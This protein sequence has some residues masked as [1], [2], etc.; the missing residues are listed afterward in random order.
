MRQTI[1]RLGCVAVAL[2]MMAP[3]AMAQTGR[4]RGTV[5][6][7]DGEPLQD[8]VIEIRGLNS[9]QVRE[10]KTG[11]NGTFL[12][13]GIPTGEYTLTCVVD[14]E[15]MGQIS[16]IRVRYQ[17]D[18]DVVFDLQNVKKYEDALRALQTTGEVTEAELEGL[19][20]EQ[21]RTIRAQMESMSGELAERKELNDAFNNAMQAKKAEQW[22]TAVENF[23]KALELDPENEVII[24]NL[25]DTYLQK[26]QATRGEDRQ[27]AL[28]GCFP[29]YE[30]M[31]TLKPDDGV[32]LNNYA[33]ALYM[34]GRI[35]EGQATLEKA[36]Q[37]DPGQAGM[38]YYNLGASLLQLNMANQNAACDAFK[39][40]MDVG[41]YAP[42]FFQYGNCLMNQMTLDENGNIVA[43]PGTKEAFEKYLEMDPSGPHAAD[44]QQMLQVLGTSVQTE[45]GGAN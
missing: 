26:A 14:G 33:L 17:E 21:K 42:A 5:I 3:A 29:I 19:T 18:S 38:Y 22:D 35:E 7:G 36:I 41:S 10:T 23:Q 1:I 8:A 25:A 15:M 43:A 32:T 13:A 39:S 37:L 45:T 4:L 24:G 40:A 2:L 6:G 11:R 27:A 30:Q 20:E 12:H 16:G 34:A 28:A 9:D 31:L 44:A